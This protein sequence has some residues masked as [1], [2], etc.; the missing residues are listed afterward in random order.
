[1]WTIGNNFSSVSGLPDMET[2]EIHIVMGECVWV[3]THPGGT[4]R[5]RGCVSSQREGGQKINEQREIWGLSPFDLS[6]FD[7]PVIEETT[8]NAPNAP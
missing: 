7:Q 5:S 8:I 2:A 1:M 6:P 4:A 3:A